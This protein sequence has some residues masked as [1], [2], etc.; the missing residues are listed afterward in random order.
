MRRKA[1]VLSVFTLLFLLLGEV[2]AEEDYLATADQYF[3][4]GKFNLA[5]IFYKKYIEKKPDSFEANYSLGKINYFNNNYAE[6]AKY[7]EMANDLKPG[8][9]L[10]FLIANTHVGNKETGKAMSLYTNLIRDYPDYGDVYL[11][12]GLVSYKYLYNKEYTIDFWEKFL[13]VSPDD[14][15]AP[16]IRKALEY[17]RDPGFTL[18]P[19]LS[20][21]NQSAAGLNTSSSNAANQSIQLDIKGKDIKSDAEEKYDLKKPKSITTE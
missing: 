11:N 20:R 17:L 4:D 15:Q 1:C 6:A 21:T 9:E 18:A 8:K 7:L 10:Q 5:E 14:I 3:N 2:I 19:P 13:K 12:A 16:K